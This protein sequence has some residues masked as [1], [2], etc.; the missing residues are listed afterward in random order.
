MYVCAAAP[1]ST[2]SVPHSITQKLMLKVNEATVHHKRGIEETKN[3]SGSSTSYVRTY[4]VCE[5]VTIITISNT[6]LGIRITMS[7]PNHLELECAS[8][9][10]GINIVDVGYF[11][12]WRACQS[13]TL[14]LTYYCST[15]RLRCY[16]STRRLR[17]CG[18]TLWL[19]YYCSTL[20]LIYY[21]GT[22]RL[23]YYG[24]T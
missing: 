12:R 23:G 21:G 24:N 16:G 2:G 4:L 9:R 14:R 19:R 7:H 17:Y 3:T 8:K 18:S 6:S 22:L 11:L 13:V 1:H 15:L 20:R 5:I 10:V